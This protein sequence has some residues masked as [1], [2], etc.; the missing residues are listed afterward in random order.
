MLNEYYNFQVANFTLD[1]P[2]FNL[3]TSIPCSSSELSFET[4]QVLSALSPA[5]KPAAL[6]QAKVELLNEYL[7]TANIQFPEVYMAML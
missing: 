3:P 4:S 2:L 5:D 7:A 6:R 1:N